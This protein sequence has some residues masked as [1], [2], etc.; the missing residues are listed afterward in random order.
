MEDRLADSL[1]LCFTEVFRGLAELTKTTLRANAASD[2]V[3]SAGAVRMTIYFRACFRQRDERSRI[4][5]FVVFESCHTTIVRHRRVICFCVLCFV[6]RFEVLKRGA[7]KSMCMLFFFQMSS[8][9]R[10]AS[11]LRSPANPVGSIP[12]GVPDA[13]CFISQLRT[14]LTGVERSPRCVMLCFG[15]PVTRDR[16]SRATTQERTRTDTPNVPDSKPA[17]EK[18]KHLLTHDL[19]QH[20][21][22]ISAR[23]RRTQGGLSSG[24][25]TSA[26][27]GGG[28]GGGEGGFGEHLHTTSRAVDLACIALAEQVVP[29]LAVCFAALFGEYPASAALGSGRGG[30]GGAKVEGRAEKLRAR[31]LSA[32]EVS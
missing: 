2:A 14:R 26:A 19:A 6:E 10:I 31:L 13:A 18:A 9:C 1:V 12:E 16:H 7:V 28:G 24:R 5:V 17:L 23:A 3:G 8:C 11:D 29:H 25:G 4:I 22:K 21:A 27:A 32:L 30:G 15:Q 20:D